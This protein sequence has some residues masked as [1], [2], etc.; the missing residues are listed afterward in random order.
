VIDD[1]GAGATS[2]D[3]TREQLGGLI[4]NRIDNLRPTMLIANATAA[5]MSTWLG[6]RMLDRLKVAGD[7]Q[8]IAQK[9]SLRA[10]ATEDL[11]PL[12][13][14]AEWKRCNR[15]VDLI[16][17]EWTDLF[18]EILDDDGRFIGFD[19]DRK[20]GRELRVGGNIL[21]VARRGGHAACKKIR[22]EL[23]LD[24]EAVRSKAIERG[25]SWM[26][27]LEPCGGSRI[28]TIARQIFAFES[29]AA[30][31]FEAAVEKRAEQE[32]ADRAEVRA[33]LDRAHASYQGARTSNTGLMAFEGKQAPL[34]AR[35]AEG[36]RKLYAHGF[37]V[38]PAGDAF[39]VYLEVGKQRTRKADGC[40]TVDRGW[41]IA[42]IL[43]ADPCDDS[44]L[45][46]AVSGLRN[47][48]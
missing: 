32:A 12:G 47:A 7:V 28:S 33:I 44:V 6:A 25:E 17:C 23:G 36:R 11:D 15:L 46:A 43:C 34:W 8:A 27:T 4:K 21:D 22:L 45:P 9:Q 42:G 20:I 2:G 39:A 19:Y 35:G 14:G 26:R 29:A 31:I 16:G 40:P 18:A 13:R 1:L 41:E 48:G 3:S 38:V 30:E 24:A 10:P 37:R 5:E